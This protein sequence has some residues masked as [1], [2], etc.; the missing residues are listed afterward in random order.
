MIEWGRTAAKNAG[1]DLQPFFNTVV[2]T[3]LWKDIGET[4][5]GVVAQWLSGGVSR[6]RRLG[7]GDSPALRVGASFF[8]WALVP[9]AGKFR[10]RVSARGGQLWRSRSEWQDN[11]SVGIVSEGRC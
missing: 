5:T 6:E 2:C 1:N 11:K 10:E 7:C 9:D 4:G 3:N 8:R